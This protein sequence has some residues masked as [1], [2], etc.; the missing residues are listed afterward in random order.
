MTPGAEGGL[1]R[2]IEA[3]ARLADAIA[4]AEREAAALVL[5]AKDEAAAAEAGWRNR[6]EAETAK[7]VA[8]V[9]SDRDGAIAAV[10][11]EAERR[12]RRLTALPPETIAA[13]AAWAESRVLEGAESP[14]L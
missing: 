7:L 13:L 1:A 5:A 8:R 14:S 11:A 10:E 4:S 2:L 6:L 12:C 9:R 3:E